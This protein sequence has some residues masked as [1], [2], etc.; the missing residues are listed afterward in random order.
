M[1]ERTYDSSFKFPRDYYT[2]IICL[3]FTIIIRLILKNYIGR[4]IWKNSKLDE[5]YKRNLSKKF[6][7]SFYRGVIYFI[8]FSIELIISYDQKWILRP[9]LFNEPWPDMPSKIAIPYFIELSH[10]TA[11]TLFLFFEPKLTDFYLMLFHHLITIYLVFL[12]YHKKYVN[13]FL[14]FKVRFSN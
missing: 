8:I 7:S 6:E 13:H 2:F 11:S 9:S 10:Y 3:I 1:K 5:S 12:S 4:K 14:V